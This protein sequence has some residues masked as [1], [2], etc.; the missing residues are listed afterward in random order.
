MCKHWHVNLIERRLIGCLPGPQ[1]AMGI[2]AV[3][4]PFDD[5][6][7]ALGEMDQL[8]VEHDACLVLREIEA[9]GKGGDGGLRIVG[10]RDGID[11]AMRIGKDETQYSVGLLLAEEGHG[12]YPAAGVMD[13]GWEL[14]GTQRA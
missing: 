2:I 6:E 3:C 5:G 9:R 10:A 4:D 1:L 14:P 13:G 11:H 8:L 12:S 7:F